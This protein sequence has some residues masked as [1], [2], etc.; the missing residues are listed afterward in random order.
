[1]SVALPRSVLQ[2]FTECLAFGSSRLTTGL[3]VS[4]LTTTAEESIGSA[5]LCAS[6]VSVTFGVKVPAAAYTWDR[7][8]PVGQSVIVPSPQSTERAILS[9]GLQ[10][11]ASADWVTVT[12]VSVAQ[13]VPG[14]AANVPVGAVRSLITTAWASTT[15]WLWAAS[16]R[17]TVGTYR[18]AASG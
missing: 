2:A 18:A 16:V 3:T 13:A 7:V 14:P 9:A 1:M 4:A 17:V 11:S 12:R 15:F 10:L 6:S 5:L 8:S